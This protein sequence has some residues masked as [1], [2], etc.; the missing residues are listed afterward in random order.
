MIYKA[1]VQ[2]LE[3]PRAIRDECHELD[4]IGLIVSLEAKS[5]KARYHTGM[6]Q[7]R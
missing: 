5:A 3:V 6:T 1:Y 4:E 2:I 7:E